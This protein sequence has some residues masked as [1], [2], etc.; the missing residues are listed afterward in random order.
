M[1][2]TPFPLFNIVLDEF[3]QSVCCNSLGRRLKTEGQSPT[4]RRLQQTKEERGIS[5]ALDKINANNLIDAEDKDNERH[6]WV[7]LQNEGLID[8]FALENSIAVLTKDNN[9]SESK[10]T[11]KLLNKSKYEFKITERVNNRG[12]LKIIQLY[13]SN[14]YE[15]GAIYESVTVQSFNIDHLPGNAH[16]RALA[17]YE[18]LASLP[19][20][21]MVTFL[22]EALRNLFEYQES[23]L[24]FH[25]Y[26]L[27]F[28]DVVLVLNLCKMYKIRGII[29]VIAPPLPHFAEGT[30]RQILELCDVSDIVSNIEHYWHVGAFNTFSS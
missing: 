9:I 6:S 11:G 24:D 20:R 16:R 3:M 5:I 19:V 22:H 21:C 30:A 7:S 10:E 17:A 8:H 12:I 26:M 13:S 2:H 15:I 18:R 29:L 14:I 4:L 28:E 1:Q 25:S 27:Y 23:I